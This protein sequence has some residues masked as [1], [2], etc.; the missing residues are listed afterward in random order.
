VYLATKFTFENTIEKDLGPLTLD[1][2]KKQ[3]GLKTLQ[4][5]N[6][7]AITALRVSDEEDIKE[8]TGFIMSLFGCESV[9]TKEDFIED[10]QGENTNWIFSAEKIRKRIKH[11]YPAHVHD[12]LV[13][14][15]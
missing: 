2:Y 3:T 12:A 10:I 9:L 15:S 14:N 8:H 4:D 5:F 1:F 13:N 11:F 6:D 7:K